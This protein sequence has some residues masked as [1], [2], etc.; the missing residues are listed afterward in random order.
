M[1]PVSCLRSQGASGGFKKEARLCLRDKY[2]IANRKQRRYWISRSTFDLQNFSGCLTRVQN[3][4]GNR[5]F[6]ISILFPA[7]VI[8]FVVKTRP[9]AISAMASAGYSMGRPMRQEMAVQRQ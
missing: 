7:E 2:R 8:P 1:V 3:K 5:K 9:R 4:N 6:G